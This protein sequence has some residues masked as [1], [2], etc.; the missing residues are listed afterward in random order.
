MSGYVNTDWFIAILALFASFGWIAYVIFYTRRV[1]RRAAQAAAQA[2]KQATDIRIA[3]VQSGYALLKAAV[4]SAAA[5]MTKGEITD[6]CCDLAALDEIIGDTLFVCAALS[7]DASNPDRAGQTLATYRRAEANYGSALEALERARPIKEAIEQKVAAIQRVSA[8]ASQ[9]IAEADQ[10][11]VGVFQAIQAAYAQGWKTAQANAELALA[12]AALERARSQSAKKRTSAAIASAKDAG[13]AAA[14][15]RE[16]VEGL[17]KRKAAVDANCDQLADGLMT[18]RVVIE[19][20]KRALKRMSESYAESS[21]EAIRDNVSKAEQYF[22]IAV[23]VLDAAC[24]ASTM[25]EQRWEDAWRA[26]REGD[27]ALRRVEAFTRE[28]LDL[29]E[30]LKAAQREPVR[31]DTD[32]APKESSETP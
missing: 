13:R 14:A 11:I 6:L 4:E 9:R 24:T 25:Q 7:A 19:R 16:I 29:E 28:I 5:L 12:R 18:T 15:A 21:W 8:E 2:K 22:E 10:T 3:E 17:P 1:L 23:A 27:A 32:S 26:V 31:P 30:R 20:A